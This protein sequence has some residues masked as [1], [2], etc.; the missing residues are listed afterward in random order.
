MEEQKENT[1][2][3]FIVFKPEQIDEIV[4]SIGLKFN[5]KD[6]LVDNDRTIKCSCC[7]RPIKKGSIGNILPGS[8]IIYCDNPVCFADYMREHL[9]L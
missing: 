9:D 8:N 4:N 2:F 6:Y 7:E 3:G 1:D 5:K